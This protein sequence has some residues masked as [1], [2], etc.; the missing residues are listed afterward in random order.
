MNHATISTFRRD[1]PRWAIS[2]LTLVALSLMVGATLAQPQDA[3]QI[4]ELTGEVGQ[5]SGLFYL[6]PDLQQG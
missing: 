3:A 6:L 4:Q 5:D 1:F 2:L